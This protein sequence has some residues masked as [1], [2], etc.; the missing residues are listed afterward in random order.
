MKPG[1]TCWLVVANTMNRFGIARILADSGFSV[2]QSV[3]Q[4]EHL[5]R[6]A[7]DDEA[8]VIVDLSPSDL[9]AVDQIAA[10]RQLFPQ[11]RI[12]ALDEALDVTAVSEAFAAGVHGYALTSRPHELFV[13]MIR[14]VATGEKVFPGALLE[15]LCEI[16]P[17]PVSQ[18]EAAADAY[19]LSHREIRLL[20][21]LA[22]GMP[23]KSIARQLE[24]SEATVKIG[25]QT[26]FRKLSVDNRT[27][28]ALF[29]R[30]SGLIA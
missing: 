29:A 12:V 30:E 2:T 18:Q 6:D 19:D 16:A 9:D 17:Q 26:L 13:A 27:Q 11:S 22:Q 10:L 23:N 8:I 4:I 15:R 1:S 28:A 3:A 25:L 24:L 7:D 5:D 20:D 21:A 14:L